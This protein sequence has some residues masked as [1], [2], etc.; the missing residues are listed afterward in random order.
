MTLAHTPALSP[1]EREELFPPLEQSSRWVGEK[2]FRTFNENR[3]LCLL[4]AG[5]G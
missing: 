1:E 3:W 2:S 4:P 5:E